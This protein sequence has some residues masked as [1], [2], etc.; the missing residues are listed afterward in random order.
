MRL[1]NL[2]PHRLR[3]VQTDGVTL[4]LAPEGLA[5][6]ET[7]RAHAYGLPLDGGRSITVHRVVVGAVTG[8]PDPRDD[9]R[10]VVS[11]QV[12]EAVAAHRTDCLI[13]DETVRDEQGRIVGARALAIL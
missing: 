9:V 13:V 2:T 10:Y 11:R 6:C 12:A 3:L 1:V 8:L 7:T 5:R 4:E